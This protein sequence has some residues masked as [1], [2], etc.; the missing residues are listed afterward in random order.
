M[1]ACETMC[2]QCSARVTLTACVRTI[3]VSLLVSIVLVCNVY[4]KKNSLFS[5][6]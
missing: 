5:R 1:Y 2:V 4:C 3:S 6:F